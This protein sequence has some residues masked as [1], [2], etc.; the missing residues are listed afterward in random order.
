MSNKYASIT[1]TM[2]ATDDDLQVMKKTEGMTNL[3]MQEFN[4]GQVAI[5]KIVCQDLLLATS[6]QP[7]QENLQ[8]LLKNIDQTMEIIGINKEKMIHIN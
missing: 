6:Y 7:L 1:F 3:S 5:L 2:S 8:R 4:G